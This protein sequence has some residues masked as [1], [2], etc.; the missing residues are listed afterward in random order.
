MKGRRGRNERLE[1]HGSGVHKEL[2]VGG[3]ES[4]GNAKQEPAVGCKFYDLF[5]MFLFL[6]MNALFPLAIW[7]MNIVKV[8][9]K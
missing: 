8:K 3:T 7:L 9:Y 1:E 5:N 6:I 2:G 4:A